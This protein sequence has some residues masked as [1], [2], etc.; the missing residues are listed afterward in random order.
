MDDRNLTIYNDWREQQ[1]MRSLVPNLCGRQR[2]TCLNK[3]CSYRVRQSRLY[4][5][6]CRYRGGFR[7]FCF[8]GAPKCELNPFCYQCS[9]I[10]IKTRSRKCCDFMRFY[11]YAQNCM[12]GPIAAVIELKRFI[13]IIYDDFLYTMEDRHVVFTIGY[14]GFIEAFERYIPPRSYRYSSR[15]IWYIDQADLKYFIIMC[16]IRCGIQK[17]LHKQIIAFIFN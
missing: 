2:F 3:N 11:K 12:M 7:H 5:H 6:R 10:D 8:C 9:K 17:D 4:C 1:R 14:N 16:L 13:D 15:I